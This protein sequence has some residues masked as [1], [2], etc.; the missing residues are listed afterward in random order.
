[1]SIIN[2][3]VKACRRRRIAELQY[4]AIHYYR[5]KFRVGL[6]SRP[7]LSPLSKL[8]Q[9]PIN[10]YFRWKYGQGDYVMN[11]DWDTLIILDACRYDDFKD[12]YSN[13]G[14]LE[15]RLSVGSDS[16]EFIEKNFIGRKLHDTVYVTANPHVRM[17][18]DGVFHTI[19]DTPLSRWDQETGCV[20]PKAVTEAAI[21]AH[22]RYSNKKIIVH[23]MQPHDPPL[24]ETGNR[25]RE[26][27]NLGGV[28]S[29]K[30]EDA[31]RMF[32]AVARG[33][34]SIDI[35]REAY[36][37][38]LD[39][40]LSEVEKLFNEIEG[41]IVV[42]ADHGEMF[43]EQ[44]YPI[45]GRLYEHYNHPYTIPL[46]KVPWLTINQG[47]RRRVLSEDPIKDYSSEQENLDEKLKALGYR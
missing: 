10:K 43:G 27:L 1:M 4:K 5:E 16:P 8:C 21:Q 40:V 37:E 25:L 22:N 38:T 7:V 45:L 11:E 26:E 34:I 44:P 47:T 14:T 33:D 46:C 24:G 2:R 15:S 29:L 39:I 19:I 36:R 6:S 23:Y 30:N 28:K 32:E 20:R 3:A 12:Q 31:K 9:Y 41:R 17:I 35:A 42:S 18:D 13:G